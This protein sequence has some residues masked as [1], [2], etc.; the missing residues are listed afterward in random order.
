[1]ACS[2]SSQT[3]SIQLR[4]PGSCHPFILQKGGGT[5]ISALFDTVRG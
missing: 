2:D 1:M 5:A 3:L 4:L